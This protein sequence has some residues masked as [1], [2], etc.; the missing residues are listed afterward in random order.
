MSNNIRNGLIAT[1]GM[2]FFVY[3]CGAFIA[4]EINPSDW[5]VGLRTVLAVV[6]FI[7][8]GLIGGIVVQETK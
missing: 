2:L 6:G 1:V 8:S 7:V 3:L 4:W 5:N